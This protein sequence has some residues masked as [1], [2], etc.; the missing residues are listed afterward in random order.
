ME[1]LEDVPIWNNMIL[2]KKSMNP[3]IQSFELESTTNEYP[4]LIE[5]NMLHDYRSKINI[6]EQSITNGKNWE[7]YKKIVNPFEL[8]YTQK[9]YEDFPE[10]I[11]FLR[12]LSRS[13]FKMIEMLDLIQFF[14]SI[15]T[16]MI[17]TAHVCEGPGGFI[18]ALFDAASKYSK[19]IQVSIAMTLKSKQSNIP[20]WKRA[21]YFLQKNKN[22]RIIFGEDQTGDIMKAINQQYFI[23]YVVNPEQGG[24]I[25][26]YTADGGFDFSYDY[27]KQEQM[28]FPLLVA[29]TKIGF[30]VLKKGGVFILKLFDFYHKSTVDLLYFLSCHFQE[31]TLYKPGMS[32]PCNPEHYFIGKGFTGCTEEVLD[33]MR[34]WCSMLENNQPLESL[35]KTEYSVEFTEIISTLREN[36]FKS[37]TEYLKRVFYII[38][39]NNSDLIQSYLKKNEKSSYDW[40]IRFNVPIYAHRRH[41]IEELHTD[42][43]AS[44]PQ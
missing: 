40:C 33:I 1:S 43:P 23:D 17:R 4:T 38:E 16:N 11:C 19:K 27:K 8:V 26:V 29:S 24:K 15:S 25:D 21:A 31:W 7:Y 3:P 9:K 37:Q 22:I 44:C 39:Q 18:E 14:E 5:E 35:Y 41:S 2:L 28:I 12:P 13:Y 34:L 32:R 42:P 30:E 20:G 36:S 6:Y 10:S